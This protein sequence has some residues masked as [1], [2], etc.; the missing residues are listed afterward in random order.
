MLLSNLGELSDYFRFN[1]HLR[2]VGLPEPVLRSLAVM[3]LR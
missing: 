1:V 2:R 3:A